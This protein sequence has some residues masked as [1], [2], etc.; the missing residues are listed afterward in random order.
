MKEISRSPKSELKGRLPCTCPSPG[1]M[2][3]H[4]LTNFVCDDWIFSSFRM[5]WRKN[6]VLSKYG[7]G[8]H[9][10]ML[11]NERIK[12]ST[13]YLLLVSMDNFSHMHFYWSFSW[14]F[15]NEHRQELTVSVNILL[16]FWEIVT[17]VR[18]LVNLV[19]ERYKVSHKNQGSHDKHFCLIW[20][21]KYELNSLFLYEQDIYQNIW[22]GEKW[23]TLIGLYL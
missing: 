12:L 23:V 14:T 13:H 21:I 22:I 9:T 18:N 6:S 17:Q 15:V 1:L 10:F 19:V 3:G 8:I 20:Q 5:K 7:L 2:Q 11:V 4:M 16:R